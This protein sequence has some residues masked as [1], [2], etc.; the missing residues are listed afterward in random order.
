MNVYDFDDTIYNGDSSVDFY[1]FCLRRHPSVLCCAPAQAGAYI[2]FRAG[3]YTRT[4]MKQIIY[5]YLRYVDNIDS[6]IRLFWNIHKKN[7]KEWY[8]KD[9]RRED[10]LIISASPEFLLAPVFKEIGVEMMGS[11]LDKYTGIYSGENCY[12]EEKPKRFYE[13]YPAGVIDEFYSDSYS[14]LPLAKLARKAFMVKG[15]RI[16]EWNI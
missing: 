9:K 4:E 15:N 6:E 10:D 12:G 13:K 16:T 7:L 5:G 1:K 2:R 8:M 11:K 3:R 14:D